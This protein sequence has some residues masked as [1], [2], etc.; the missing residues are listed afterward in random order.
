MG[1]F[2]L[3]V[4]ILPHPVLFVTAGGEV[5]YFNKAFEQLSGISSDIALGFSVF[6]FFS[7][8]DQEILK[9]V[10]LHQKLYQKPTFVKLNFNSNQRSNIELKIMITAEEEGGKMSGFSCL[11]EQANALTSEVPVREPLLLNSLLEIEE[12]YKTLYDL[13]FEG[14]ILHQKGIIIDANPAFAK[15]MGY[16]KEEFIG[17]NIV[18]LC[19]L[20]EYHQLVYNA[21]KS[22]QVAPYE[23]M[24]KRK[25][26]TIIHTEVESRRINP[27]NDLVRAT[28]I[29]DITIRKRAEVQLK[30]SEERYKLLS[31]ITFE[32]IF[33]HNKGIIIDANDSLADMIGFKLDEIIGK[34]IVELVVFPEYRPRVITALNNEETAPYEVKVKRKDGSEF[35]AEVEARMVNYHGEW[36]RVTAARDITWRKE[37]ER[38]IRENEE[39]LDTF[40]SQS[41]DGF[42]IMNMKKPVKWDDESDKEKLLDKVLRGMQLTKINEAMLAQYRTIREKINGYNLEQFF[43]WNDIFGRQFTRE[44]LDNGS[45]KFEMAEPRFD[46]SIMWIEGNYVVLYD[47]NGNVRGC[48]GVRRE[49]SDRKK[50]EDSI[51]KHNEEL[52][53]ANQELDNFV[54]RVSHDLKAPISSAKGLLQIAQK[55]TEMARVRTCLELLENSMDKLDSFILDI[56]DY[57]RNSRLEI[58]PELIDFDRLIKETVSNTRYL[59][60]ERNIEIE[61]VIKDKIDF[62]SDRRRLVFIFNNLIS[63]AI[64]FSDKKKSQSYLRI[65]IEVK[66]QQVLM[67]FSDNGIG[68]KPEYVNHIFNMFYRA[69]EEQVG[70]G[71]GLYIVKEALDKL[72]GEIKVKSE[73]GSGTQFDLRIPNMAGSIAHIAS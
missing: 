64:R 59:Q 24:A 48:C 8:V 11:I 38:R 5:T 32:G 17:K 34:N 31:N 72:N 39:E 40:F 23:V 22:G 29:R 3:L 62:Y 51:K 25:D 36:L 69:T 13:T 6:D 18:E 43:Q 68:I 30:E 44:L 16:P 70:S 65:S 42:F 50:I 41:G 52:K 28:A 61:T 33:L 10:F 35:F 37:A 56:L 20:P 14:I 47:E 1:N 9:N 27:N 12:K 19:V 66:K 58:T 46:K 54:Y 21:M 53:K 55:E 7:S 73:F 45:L 15:M 67:S 26:G 2:H 57:S 49:I 63:N 71:L 4:D 60:L